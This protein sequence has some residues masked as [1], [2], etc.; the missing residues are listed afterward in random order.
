[1]S[2]EAEV[3]G[4]LRSPDTEDD[5]NRRPCSNDDLFTTAEQPFIGYRESLLIFNWVNTSATI[6]KTGRMTA[7]GLRWIDFVVLPPIFFGQSHAKQTVYIQ[8]IPPAQFFEPHP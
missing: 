5:E 2:E 7:D 3:P 8:D 6:H 1:M 4:C